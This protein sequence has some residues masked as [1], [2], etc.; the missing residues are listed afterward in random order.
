MIVPTECADCGIVVPE[1]QKGNRT[2]PEVRGLRTDGGRLESGPAQA[3]VAGIA[4]KG[5]AEAARAR[6]WS[7]ASASVKA[8]CVAPTPES[9]SDAASLPASP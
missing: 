6:I 9:P 7:R 3:L 2:A 5:T 4:D 1:Y 8:T